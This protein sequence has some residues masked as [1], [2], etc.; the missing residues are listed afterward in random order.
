VRKIRLRF[1]LPEDGW[2]QVT[3]TS[4]KGTFEVDASDVPGD[5]LLELAAGALSVARASSKRCVIHWHLEPE[6]VQ[7]RI[8]R[9]GD[10]ISL[11]VQERPGGPFAKV[12]TGSAEDILVPIWR[13]LQRLEHDFGWESDD[14]RHWSN[15]FPSQEV[16][17]LGDLFQ[18]WV[19]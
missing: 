8:E 4:R 5:S 19:G 17:Q 6:W 14:F 13:G 10:R 9:R 16:A 11:V 2:I 7:W 3:L 12:A 18:L 15:P 1:G